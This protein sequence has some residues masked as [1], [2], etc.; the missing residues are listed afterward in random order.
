MRNFV[1]MTAILPDDQRVVITGLGPIN[2]MGNDAVS[3]FDGLLAGHSSIGSVSRFDTEGF[4]CQI[5]SQVSDDFKAADYFNSPKTV[6]SNDRFT[7]FAVAA[8][9]VALEDADLSID[10][11]DA[12]RM[13]AIVGSAFGGMETYETQTLKLAKSGP[14]RVS[15]FT[16]P[17]LLGNTAAGVVGIEVGAKGPNFGVTSACATASHAMGEAMA[18]IRRGDADVML[19]GGSDAAVTPTSFA[20]FCSMKAL[21]SQYNDNP[22]KGS[23]PF[24]ADRCGFVMGEGAGVLVLESLTHAVKRGARIYCELAGYGASCDAYHITSPAPGG[25]GLARAMAQALERGGVSDLSQVG[26]INAHGTSTAYNDKFETLAIKSIFK[27]E[28]RNLRVSSTK[29]ATGHTLGAAGGLEAIV[30]AKAIATGSIPPT[31]NYETPDPECDLDITPNVAVKGLDIKVALSTNLGFGG[32][33][34]ALC[35]KALE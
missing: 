34:A 23:R 11:M 32:H 2:G 33:N 14:K 22:T 10:S 6:K 25:E 31:I 5:A 29:G 12:T 30:C 18:A 21:C 26:Y 7:H 15:P 20:G 1:R 24:D 35:F 8:A 13:G 27:E 19:A 17:A 3:F 16:I 28:A 9:R 4:N